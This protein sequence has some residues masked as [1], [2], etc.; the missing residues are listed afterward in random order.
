M[1]IDFLDEFSNFRSAFKVVLCGVFDPRMVEFEKLSSNLP[2]FD[3][4]KPSALRV[5]SGLQLGEIFF[6]DTEC[7]GLLQL[8]LERVYVL[9]HCLF[10]LFNF[11][12]GHVLDRPLLRQKLNLLF[13]D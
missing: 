12:S 4:G 7:G 8:R 3:F 2:C 10:A 11:F 6:E 9:N 5:A 13:N 1:P